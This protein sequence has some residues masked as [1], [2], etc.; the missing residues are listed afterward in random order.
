MAEPPLIP[1]MMAT[2]LG[3]R[4][5]L[6]VGALLAAGLVVVGAL[7]RAPHDG[8]AESPAELEVRFAVLATCLAFGVL[9]AYLQQRE[10]TSMEGGLRLLAE[11][12]QEDSHISRAV[13]RAK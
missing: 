3:G 10:R 6:Y 4:G 9:A 11:R 7:P 1:L 13:P 12:L 5:T 2:F 8:A